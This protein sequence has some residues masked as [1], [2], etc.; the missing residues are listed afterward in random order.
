MNKKGYT[1]L[2]YEKRV[3]IKKMLEDDI[4]PVN[5][6]EKIGVSS[7]TV[8]REIKRNTDNK[9]SYSPVKSQNRYQNNLHHSGANAIMKK[10]PM[11][12]KF[13]ADKILNENM[14]PEKIESYIRNNPDF[15]KGETVSRNTIYNAIDKGLIP[16][17]TRENLNSQFTVMYSD[18]MLRI[19]KWAL[20]KT[21]FSN[22]DRFLIDVS[23]E[24]RITFVKE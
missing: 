20:E 19:P 15:F 16:G 17:V 2:T 4:S 24:V 22:G 6:A 23:I 1:H 8:Y 10:Y 3:Q 12:A 21:G 14:S 7:S 13:I 5:I 11:L 9:D 18:G